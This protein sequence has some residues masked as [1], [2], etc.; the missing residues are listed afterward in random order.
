MAEALSI[1]TLVELKSFLD[2]V[3][4][5]QALLRPFA[6]WKDYPV[7]D[8]RAL[9]PSFEPDAY[10]YHGLPGFSLVVLDRPLLPFTEMFQYDILHPVGD[11]LE[12]AQGS[13]LS[14]GEKYC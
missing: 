1:T 11:F 5:R 14:T 13:M 10:E 4:I 7:V 6:E 3:H 12:M 2:M 8:A 9:L